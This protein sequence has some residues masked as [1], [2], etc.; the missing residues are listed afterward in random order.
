MVSNLDLFINKSE[1]WKKRV[2]VKLTNLDT[3]HDIQLVAAVMRDTSD[4]D[5]VR[6]HAGTI[7]GR[8][9]SN[10]T[11]DR[12]EHDLKNSTDYKTR[13]FCLVGL[14][15]STH[16][17][18]NDILL[19]HL[20]DEQE[21]GRIRQAACYNLA[22]R[23]CADVIPHAIHYI[24]APFMSED[25]FMGSNL[26]IESLLK[27]DSSEGLDA[28]IN[29]SM[30]TLADEA[31]DSLKREHAASYLMHHA[32]ERCEAFLIEMIDN[33]IV[34]AKRLYAGKSGNHA[35][36][37]LQRLNTPAA[38]TAIQAWKAS[39]HADDAAQ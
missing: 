29:W 12:L 37:A 32:D 31:Q 16:P 7:L 17:R 34:S 38:N 1:F 39:Q 2:S 20:T 15:V 36:E 24:D 25:T 4:M 11:I 28:I 23:Q 5:E 22:I 33:P 18:V 26:A 3:D 21:D 6:E 14:R 35:I 10:C 19:K 8:I 13:L 9:S 27:F 30:K